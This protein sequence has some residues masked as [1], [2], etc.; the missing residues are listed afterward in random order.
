MRSGTQFNMSSYTTDKKST[1]DIIPPCYWQPKII[2]SGFLEFL[3]YV[4]TFTL[5]EISGKWQTPVSTSQSCA[6][7]APHM[8]FCHNNLAS[9]VVLVLM[10]TYA[11]ANASADRTKTVEFN[12]KPGG[13][14]H[15]FAKKIVSAA[16][17]FFVCHSSHKGLANV[18]HKPTTELMLCLY[19]NSKWLYAIY[20]VF[21]HF[22]SQLV[23]QSICSNKKREKK[24][25][26][27]NNNNLYQPSSQSMCDLKL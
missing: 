7:M 20:S 26:K 1:I 17:V 4:T 19:V 21:E 13:V 6:R 25:G 2:H 3:P 10:S 23:D 12:V 14:V 16:C 11:L 15:T 27:N 9:F 5:D 24:H 8:N 18:T 22:I